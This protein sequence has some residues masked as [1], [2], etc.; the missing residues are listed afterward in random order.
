MTGAA[1]SPH[2]DTGAI[3]SQL[4]WHQGHTEPVGASLGQLELHCAR[5]EPDGSAL[6]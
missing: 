5:T 3:L 2:C 4:R 1:L 6:R